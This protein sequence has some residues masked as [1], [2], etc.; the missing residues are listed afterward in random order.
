MR[1]LF[2]LPVIVICAIIEAIKL[3]K[4][5]KEISEFRVEGKS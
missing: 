4:N 5:K 2:L 3:L 1:T